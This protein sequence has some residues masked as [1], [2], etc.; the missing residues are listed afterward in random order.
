MA[1][2]AGRATIALRRG[3]ASHVEAG[4]SAAGLAAGSWDGLVATAG[5]D[6]S[7]GAVVD[8]RGVEPA[9]EP[10]SAARGP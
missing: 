6:S 3:G 10:G 2:G 4:W 8:C 9:A 5:P 7:A 1:T